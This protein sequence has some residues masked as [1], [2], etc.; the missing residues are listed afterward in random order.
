MGGL[1]SNDDRWTVYAK[2]YR[3]RGLL[4]GTLTFGF[5]AIDQIDGNLSWQKPS[6]KDQAYPAGFSGSIMVEGC[7]Y[8]PPAHGAAALEINDWNLAIGSNVLPAPVT[9]IATLDRHNRFILIGP[10]STGTKLRLDPATGLIAGRIIRDGIEPVPF[11][12]VLLQ[13]RRIGRGVVSLPG[14]TG[15]FTL[16]PPPVP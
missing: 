4:G 5:R 3:N 10:G 1:I 16:D 9:A 6:S 2:P 12:G 13:S 7:R 11:K 15:P 14:R 8:K